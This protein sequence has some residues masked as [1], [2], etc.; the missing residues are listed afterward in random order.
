[1]SNRTHHWSSIDEAVAVLREGMSPPQFFQDLDE[2]AYQWVTNGDHAQ[3]V[4]T[5]VQP[6]L[7]RGQAERHA[8]CLPT[9]F[10]GLTPANRPQNLTPADRARLLLHRVRLEE[11]L[12]VLDAHP[13]SAFARDLPLI[14]YPEAIAQH[15][16]ILTD[17]IDLAQDMEVAAFFATNTRDENGCWRAI[18]SGKGVLY[19]LKIP[20]DVFTPPF[21]GLEW[22]GRQALPRP[23][24][25]RAWT[26]RLPLGRDFE[27]LPVDIYTVRVEDLAATRAVLV[28]LV[29][30]LDRVADA[31]VRLVLVEACQLPGYPVRL[32]MQRDAQTPHNVGAARTLHALLA[33]DLQRDAER[34]RERFQVVVE[35]E[36]LAREAG[37]PGFGQVPS[38]C[39]SRSTRA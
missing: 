7:Y 18:G 6:F 22:I 17:R 5:L 31:D 25:Q 38:C 11:F 32:R 9:V 37:G 16:E 10:R 26:L 19:R 8:P 21:K 4:P 33:D 34:G 2:H 1:M 30:R 15:Y 3:L 28:A 29:I 24:E 35:I 13:A 27:D 12:C 20:P 39:L 14:T 36:V 23:G